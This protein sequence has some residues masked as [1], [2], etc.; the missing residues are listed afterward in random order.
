[1]DALL[2]GRRAMRRCS[3]ARQL[4][5]NGLVSISNYASR[6]EARCSK[7]HVARRPEP[8]LPVQHGPCTKAV[9]TLCLRYY[10]SISQACRG[11]RKGGETSSFRQNFRFCR[12]IEVFLFPRVHPV[13]PPDLIKPGPSAQVLSPNFLLFRPT[14]RLEIFTLITPP[15]SP[16]LS[17]ISI[18]HGQGQGGKGQQDQ[19]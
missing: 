7:A 16:S 1:M 9:R 14:Y 11:V 10:Q 18:H 12:K 19:G 17:N 3:L 4:T 2:G 13:L 5:T 6:R 8:S 15:I